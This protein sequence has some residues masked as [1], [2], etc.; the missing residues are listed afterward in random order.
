M[1][2]P[3]RFGVV[4]IDDI[5]NHFVVAKELAEEHVVGGVS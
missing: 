2:P 5:T 4:Y 1:P 3:D